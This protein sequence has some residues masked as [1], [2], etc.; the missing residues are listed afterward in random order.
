[1]DLLTTKQLQELLQV[2]RITIYRMLEDGRLPGFKVGGRWR[3]SRQEIEGWLL[4]QRSLSEASG[5]V[6]EPDPLSTYGQ[7]LPLSCVQAIQGIYAEALGVAAVTTDAEGTPLTA[8]SHSCEFCDLILST[9][10]G[11]RR[12]AVAWR[13]SENDQAHRCHANLLC[14]AR[15]VD[16]QGEQVAVVATCQLASAGHWEPRLERLAAD[17]EIPAEKLQGAVAS[18]RRVPEEDLPRLS[19]LLGCVADTFSQIAQERA[20]LISRLQHIAQMSKI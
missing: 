15:P 6:A 5:A 3:F 17:L 19:W 16:L 12:C 11:W 18:V 1:V 2:D 14:M 8:I 10:V 9:E 4:E 7:P 20:S 13:H